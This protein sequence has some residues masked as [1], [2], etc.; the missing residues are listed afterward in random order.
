VN[1][2]AVVSLPCLALGRH[3]ASRVTK[4]Q[5]LKQK[6]DPQAHLKSKGQSLGKNH[7]GEEWM[8]GCPKIWVEQMMINGD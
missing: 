5:D 3:W 6:M 4:S 7:V 8:E 2:G 1:H